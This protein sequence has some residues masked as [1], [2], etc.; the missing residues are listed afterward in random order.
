MART[1]VFV[2]GDSISIGYGPRLRD[3]LDLDHFEYARKN[4][5]ADPADTSVSG[6]NGGDSRMVL[7]YLRHLPAA[8]RSHVRNGWLLINC[9]LH[10]IKRR[11]ARRLERGVA[12][13][14]TLQVPLQE[15]KANVAEIVRLGREQL[16]A[17]KLVWLR[18]TP[19]DDEIH[20]ARG[21]AAAAAFTRHA[22][23][24][25][26]YNAAAD[27]VCAQLGVPIIDLHALSAAVGRAAFR[28][29]VHYEP[30][31]C[32][33]QA[34]YVHLECRYLR[35]GDAEC[36]HYSERPHKAAKVV[37]VGDA[38]PAAAPAISGA[39]RRGAPCISEAQWRDFD[40][41]GWVVLPR[42]QVWPA[43]GEAAEFTALCDEIDRIQLGC[44]DV[45][46]T[47]LMMQLDSTT[48]EYADAGAQTLGFKGPT[49]RYR[50]I[51]NLELD[52]QVMAYV[53]KGV[54]AE[55]CAHVY[56]RH[57]PIASFRTMLFAKPPRVSE[58]VAGGTRLPW[59]QDRWSVLDRDPL[60][61]AYLALDDASVASGCLHAVPGS[62][63]LGVLNSDHH[64]AF[65]TDAQAA[66][67]CTADATVPLPLKA[68]DLVLMHNHVI[69]SSGVNASAHPRRALSVS[70]MDARTRY[71][72]AA[73]EAEVGGANGA[74]GYPEG[75]ADFPLIFRA[76]EDA[77][78]DADVEPVVSATL[79]RR[80]VG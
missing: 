77:E 69:H 41:V 34:R 23:D 57:T 66:A 58:A 51:Q 68:G 27:E 43:G 11:G 28:D 16:G 64:S 45:P 22:S 50:K 14:G 35:D 1:R 73:F 79:G 80:G 36:D 42:S 78:I 17:V 38:S 31:V 2:V 6:Q 75:G 39:Q 10:D 47:R 53:R 12:A 54:M 32:D 49:L 59:H 33:L 56:G 26:A 72:R 70:F 65:L 19:V 60:L 3:L 62:H 21:D 30:R 24:V 15:Y 25:A 40:E 8:E 9:G 29:H 7:E 63:R 52:P 76:D 18:T 67:H 4:P 74:S 48:G 46:Y 37:V 13:D 61:N 20:A 55:A 71:S 44:A 5:A